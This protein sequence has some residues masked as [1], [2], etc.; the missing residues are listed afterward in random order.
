MSELEPELETTPIEPDVVAIPQELAVLP[1]ARHRRLPGVDDAARDRPGAL[2]QARRRR[3]R[4][5]PDARAAGHARPGQRAT[6]VQGP[7]RGRDRG[8]DPQD[9]PRPRRD[10]ARPRAGPPPDPARGARAGR[11]LSRRAL[12]RGA[13]RARGDARGRGVDPQ[14]AGAVRAHHRA[15]PVPARGA[16]ARCRERRRPE[17]ALP[18]RRVDAATE[19]RGEAGAAR[20]RERRAAAPA[21]LA[22]P[23]PRARGLRARDADPV[24][25]PV[26]DGEGAAR[27]LPAPADEGDPGRARRERPGARRGRGAS[28]AA[29]VDR[30]PGGRAQGGGA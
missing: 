7:L 27:V 1:L 30:A 5:R 20:G 17:R 16:G 18:P 13:G 11:A 23:E 25:G 24:A 15:R 3:R 19:D 9:D 2:D 10:A 12:R 26:G 29:A 22:H 8:R 28:R 14:R 4:R 6:R 21:R